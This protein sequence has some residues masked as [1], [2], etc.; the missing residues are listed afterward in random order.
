[1]E[2][3]SINRSF[4]FL[5]TVEMEIIFFRFFFPN[6]KKIKKNLI[7]NLREMRKWI[8]NLDLIKPP[9]IKLWLNN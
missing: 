4:F 1:M 8:P 6:K 3:D 2:I 9:I 7:S 5:E